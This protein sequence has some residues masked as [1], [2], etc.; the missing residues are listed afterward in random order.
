MNPFLEQLMLQVR[1]LVTGMGEYS[2]AKMPENM[3][4]EM[5]KLGF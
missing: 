1:R 2:E 4:L 3:R 5:R